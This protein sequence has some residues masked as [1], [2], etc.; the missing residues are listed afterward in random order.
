[1]AAFILLVLVFR[2]EGIM[3]AREFEWRRPAFGRRGG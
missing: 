3:R 2:R 1:L